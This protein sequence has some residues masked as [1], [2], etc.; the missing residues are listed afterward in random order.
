MPNSNKH[1]QI[2]NHNYNALSHLSNPNPSNYTDWCI[3]IIFYMAL[4]FVQAYLADKKNEH[5]T[6]HSTLQQKIRED[7]NLRS[8]YNTYRHLQDDSV[9]ARYNGD[10]LSIYEMRNST[11]K[12]FKTIQNKI[13]SLLNVSDTNKYDLYPLFPSN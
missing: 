8:T 11:L 6:N 13:I 5:I 12:Y 7:Q 4:H 10:K 1:L 9:N 3:T 2:I